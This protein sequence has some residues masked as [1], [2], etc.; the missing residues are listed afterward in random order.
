MGDKLK[1][2]DREKRGVASEAERMG[3][4][5]ERR[6]YDDDPR[7]SDVDPVYLHRVHSMER[8]ILE[9]LRH[10]GIAAQLPS[11][12]VMD[13]GCGN[14]KWFGRWLSWGAMPEHLSGTDIRPAAI[15][16][17]RQRFPQ[18]AIGALKDGVAPFP[19]RSVDLVFAN[20]VLSSILG[21]ERRQSVASDIR[22]LVRPGG[23]VLICDFAMNNP[24]NPD[25][26]AVRPSDLRRHF[27]GLEVVYEARLVLAPPLARRMVPWS[28]FAADVLESAAPPLRT[29]RLMGFRAPAGGLQP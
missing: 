15:D 11:L 22:R 27:Q 8:R 12:R 9:A 19:D 18:V 24:S 1:P 16:R 28:W 26:R 7:Y 23:H 4:V 10:L 17:A 29:H 21:E 2:P 14:G 5:Y 3:G 25:V 13:Y 6:R 20:L